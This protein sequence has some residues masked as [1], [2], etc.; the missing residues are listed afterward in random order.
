MFLCAS[1]DRHISSVTRYETFT[2]NKFPFKT[3]A[4]TKQNKK[5]HGKSNQSSFYSDDF[6]VSSP[7]SGTWHTFYIFVFGVCSICINPFNDINARK[8]VTSKIKWDR[9]LF[10]FAV[11]DVN[12]PHF[13]FLTKVNGHSIFHRLALNTVY[14]AWQGEQSV[15][16][17]DLHFRRQHR[18]YQMKYVPQFDNEHRIDSSKKHRKVG[19]ANK[20]YI[21]YIPA[22]GYR[23]ISRKENRGFERKKKKINE[24]KKKVPNCVRI[25]WLIC[26]GVGNIVRRISSDENTNKNI[27]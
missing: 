1:I 18:Q 25:N 26:F 2:A 24:N 4:Q 11:A 27:K 5:L 22:F 20:C 17:S 3:R 14:L 9:E 10:L 13:F 16:R 12:I 23:Y 6:A 19:S 21:R 7:S 8:I 15:C